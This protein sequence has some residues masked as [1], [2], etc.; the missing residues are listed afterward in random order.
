MRFQA[1]CT[2][3]F[4]LLQVTKFVSTLSCDK[5]FTYYEEYG[6]NSFNVSCSG[7]TK[8]YEHL[9]E[10]I[11][12]TNEISLTLT[13]SILENVTPKLF[14]NVHDIKILHILN[15]SFEFD[16]RAAIFS[17]LEKLESLAVKDTHLILDNVM[18]AGLGNLRHLVLSNNS[19]SGVEPGGFKSLE[20]LEKLEIVDNHVAKLQDLPLCELKKLRTLNLRRN[21][22]TSLKLFHFFCLRRARPLDLQINSL[23]AVPNMYGSTYFNIT[24][25]YDL[26][27]LDLSENQIVDL[28]YSLDELG[29][30][31]LLNIGNNKLTSIK[32]A[33]FKW[34]T[35]LQKLIA[36]SNQL[37][38]VDSRIFVNKTQL[39][40]IDLSNNQLESFSMQDVPQLKHLSLKSNHIV[41]ISLS[42]LPSLKELDLSYNSLKSFDSAS[43][44]NVNMLVLRLTGNQIQLTPGCFQSLASLRYLGLN[45]NTLN[46]IP[47]QA[48]TSLKTL[49]ILDLSWNNL[50][51]LE[52]RVF[53][54]LVNLEMLNLSSNSIESLSY[55]T[56]EPLKNLRSLDIA[57]NKLVSI[58][59]DI[60]LSKLPWLSN[61]NIKA[62]QLS[63]NNLSKIIDYLKLKHIVY[64]NSETLD[65]DHLSQNVAG[66]PCKSAPTSDRLLVAEHSSG[67]GWLNFGLCLIGI[68][69]FILTSIV[70][71]RFYIYL[72]RR[73]YRA[74]EFELVVD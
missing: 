70:T 54:E 59:Y 44:T 51:K 6:Q 28:G 49:R 62:N 37:R 41:S 21:L 65:L 5:T 11:T 53:V 50:K 18:L 31:R 35:K 39:T 56:L 2:I 22:I 61:I 10:N 26:I 4:T 36:N 24:Y 3:F 16:R 73:R 17:E 68:L 8:G 34:L 45:N 32:Y 67:R 38:T 12:I 40:F 52:K 74:D 48:F 46:D 29:K 30:L 27:E 57:A 72:K 25:T 43:L 64:V 33:H 69:V 58:E 7:I 66:I 63:C 20:N 71:Y 14:K 9:L 13:D 23:P 55:E 47:E 15:C 19:L 60:I 42:N 1:A